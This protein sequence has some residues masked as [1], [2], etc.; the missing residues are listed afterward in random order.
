MSAKLL[1]TVGYLQIWWWSGSYHGWWY[2]YKSNMLLRI[3][4]GS[5]HIFWWRTK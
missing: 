3:S 2:F 5:L 4:F 1:F